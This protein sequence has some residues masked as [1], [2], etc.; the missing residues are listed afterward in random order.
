MNTF[1][2]KKLTSKVFVLLTIVLVL[3]LNTW[4]NTSS[5]DLKAG[6]EKQDKK[7]NL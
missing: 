1:I 5:F 2:N 3:A 7:S 4:L 6:K